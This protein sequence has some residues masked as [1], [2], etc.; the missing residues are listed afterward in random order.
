MRSPRSVFHR[1]ALAS[2][3]AL[4]SLSTLTAC[5]PAQVSDVNAGSAEVSIS[6]LSVADVVAVDLTISGPNLTTPRVV[7]M[8]N[9]GGNWQVTVGGLPA[10]TNYLFT[11]SARDAA[12][13]VL[14]SG[15][16]NNV[17]VTPGQP[18][19]VVITAQSVTAPAPFANAA[20]VIDA[21]TISSRAVAQGEVVTAKATAHDP[22][23][24]DQLTYEWSA[25]CGTVATPT[26][27]TVQWTAPASDGAC[28]LS[29][30][31]RD[32]RGASARASVT[33]TVA[34]GN[35]RGAAQVS[36]TLNDTPVVSQVLASP[37]YLV[38]GSAASLSALA[39]DPQGDPLTY[40]W[41]S[42]CAGTFSGSS[43]S[44]TF[45]PDASV[46]G[47]CA[48]NVTV[49]DN[50]GASSNGSITVPVGAPSF[51][52]APSI[53]TFVQSSAVAD[54]GDAV[55]LVVNASDP[56]GGVLTF[57]WSA[58]AGTLGTQTDSSGSSQIVWTAPGA[59]AS[60]WTI[61]AQVTDSAGNTALQTFTVKGVGRWMTGDFHQHT[62]FTDG[63]Y[64]MNDLT[65]SGVIATSAVSDPSTL[66]QKGVMPQGFRF[67]LDIQSNSEHGGLRAR[68][69]FGNNWTTYSP[70]PAVGDA[71]SGQMWR[72]QSLLRTSDIP[73]YTGPAYMGAY[74]WI[75]GIRAA[76]PQKL[77]LTG[78]EWNPPG[79]EHST[80]GIVSSSPLP[81]AE[82]EYRFDNSDSD[83]TT[84]SATAT[85][86]GW[87]GKRQN[88]T[89]TAPDFSTSL[90]LNAKHEKTMAA[91][92]WMQA[93]YPT[94]GWII[95]AHV[96]RAGCGVGAWSIAAF[97]DMNDAGPTVAFGM[98]GIPGH[99][100]SSNRGEF[101]AS[102][103]GGGTFGGA[104]KYVAE[105]GGLWDNLLADGR[106]FYNF[107]SSDFHNDAGADFW[108]GEYLKTYVKVVDANADGVFSQEEVIA[109][110][111]SG[112]VYS[113]HG[114]LVR[115]LQFKAQGAAG[116]AT[117]GQTLAVAAGSSVTVSVR[118]K[119]PTTNNC[120]AGVNA[121][122]SYV[123]QAPS[124]HHVQLIQGR[125][126][127]TK[128]SKLNPDG[129]ANPAFN[130]IDA[131]V[132]SVVR[133]FDASSWT[134]DAEGFTT[135]TFV[136]PSVG[137]DMFFRV[138]G[139][140][141]GYGVSKTDGA[142]KT[143]YGIDT[144]GN[145]LL[146]TPGTNN[147]DMAWDDLWFY[148]NPIFVRKL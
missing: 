12:G 141:L 103:C 30:V 145:P 142:G 126:N 43:A 67:G 54:T 71:T 86:L 14:Y 117:M 68:D 60:A 6:K 136:V 132:A 56:E 110:Y 22:D 134:V 83:G 129:T 70:A 84:T 26:A 19:S 48:I 99:E 100:K 45:T 137:N 87:A 28:V 49:A 107:A 109:S 127:A 44:P 58:S 82:F 105:V 18:V 51:N 64:P 38:P 24:A 90:A 63:S 121:S 101:S 123:C 11:V 91:V 31:V 75:L 108:P 53:D 140:N 15:V 135:M 97:R 80:S 76:Y 125:V 113:V 40:A 59:W 52:V 55:T 42:P 106:K 39:S 41:S 81:I 102:A 116:S 66:Y 23:A 95:P 85:A 37:G 34:A 25:T 77:A 133:T 148:S 32:S 122:A 16:A 128:A 20:P 89:Y 72:W 79:H 111:R 5:D 147:A 131:S 7:S 144:A 112:N 9:R 27:A 35:G 1:Y 92:R 62:Y 29:V 78:M 57:A 4:G 73:G 124:V 93:N 74:D 47:A 61:S 138:R 96:E 98:E 130:A 139:T 36:A 65:A 118:F 2:V 50:H 114:D 94:T 69:G 146:N 119:T 13:T 143:I 8:F 104:G 46:T 33:V 88:G 21:L 17:T 3:L 10:G 120:Q 115:E